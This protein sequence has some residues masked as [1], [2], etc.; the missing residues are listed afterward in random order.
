MLSTRNSR[1]RS[2]PQGSGASRDRAREREAES[3]GWDARRSPS[4]SRTRTDGDQQQGAPSRGVFGKASDQGAGELPHQCPPI[5]SAGKP[6]EYLIS[7]LERL[8]IAKV[9]GVAFPFFM[10]NSN[11]V[12][13]FEMMDS[14]G[15]G[16]ISF[17][18]YKEALKTLGLCTEDGDLKDDGHIITLDKF[19]EEVNKRMKEIWSA[20]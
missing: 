12:A 5:L 11:I 9:T 14:S 15:R 6:R 10:D 18:Q 13:M 3:H 4:N 19:K 8:R 20:F 1:S 7:L 16:T 17:V 2:Q